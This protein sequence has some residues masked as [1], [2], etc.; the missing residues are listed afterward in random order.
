VRRRRWKRGLFWTALIFALLLVWLIAQVLRAAEATA[1]A[2]RS[3][4]QL[5]GS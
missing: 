4:L 1:A 2:A 3:A 5:D